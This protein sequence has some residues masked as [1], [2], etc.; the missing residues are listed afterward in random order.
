MSRQ[1]SEEAIFFVVQALKLS[2]AERSA[3]PL[4]IGPAS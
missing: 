2:L 4:Y 1:A 3:A